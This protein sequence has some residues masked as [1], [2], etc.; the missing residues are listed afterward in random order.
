MGSKTYLDTHVVIWLND[1]EIDKL[2]DRAYELIDT[3]NLFLSEFVRLE[4]QYLQEIERLR[5]EPDTI[6]SFLNA[7]INLTLCDE[8]LHS[9]MTEALLYGWT[10][11]PFDRLITANASIDNNLLVTK[12]DSIRDNYEYAVF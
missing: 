12:D 6:V 2:S 10:R 5:V 3:G 4:L 11:D 7:E 9:I 1:I 8:S